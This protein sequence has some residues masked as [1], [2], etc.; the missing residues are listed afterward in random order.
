MKNIRLHWVQI[1]LHEPFRISSGAIAVKDAIVVEYCKDGVTGWGEASPMAGAFYS[2]ETPESTWAALQKLACADDPWSALGEFEGEN[3]AKAG[4][5]G[6]IVDRDLRARGVPLW[7]WLESTDRPVPS[8]VAIGIYDTVEELLARVERFW[9]EGYQRV[10]VKIQPGWDVEPVSRIREKFPTIPLMVD[11]NAAYALSDL[12]IFREMDRFH[13]MMYEQPLGRHAL[14]D[15]AELA[16]SVRTPVCADESAESMEMLEKI[17]ELLA[18]QIV[19]IKIQRVGGVHMARR[20]HDR[21]MQAGLKCWVGTMPELGI[22]SVEA[23]HLATL[24]NFL[25][26]T[27]VESFSRWYVDDLVEPA[28]EIDTSGFLRPRQVEVNLEKLEKYTIRTAEF[29]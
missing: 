5:A 17:I 14:E 19:N 2:Q 29:K 20:M 25:Y 12:P 16:R 6:A 24:P 4:L 9:P 11:A 23:V 21:A 26:P 1:P 15:S 28:I 7:Q 27:D 22:A 3:F 10:K 8:G 18:A 13:L